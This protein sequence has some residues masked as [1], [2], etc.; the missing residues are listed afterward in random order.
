MC[1]D[2]ADPESVAVQRGRAAHGQPRR[3]RSGGAFA[4]LNALSD[5][6]WI[7]S[8]DVSDAVVW[9][10]SDHAKSITCVALCVDAGNTVKKGN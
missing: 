5:L 9:L 2:A 1:Q 4:S 8:N 6:P 10:S 3:R 7:E